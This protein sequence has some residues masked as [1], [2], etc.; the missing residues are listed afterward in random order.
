MKKV[1]LGQTELMV[2]KTSF[3]ALPI[4]RISFD[5]AGRLLREAY[6]AGVNFY[7]T[8]NAYTDSEKK[9]GQALGDVRKDIVIATKTAPGELDVMKRHL[10]QSLRDLRTDYIDIYQLHCAPKL[11]RPGE[12]DGI[13]D[14]MLEMKR[15]GVIR[16]IGITAHRIGVAEEA[17]ESGLYETLQFP[18]SVLANE[19]EIALVHTAEKRD[20]GF[21]AMK[22]MAGGLISHPEVTFA[23]LQQYPQ[24][25]P[26]YGIQR[27]E[28]LRQW[29]ALDAEPPRWD[30]RMQQLAQEEKA[31]LS[32]D[33]CRACGYCLPC[34]Q[35][36]PIPNAARLRLLMTR[37]PYKPYLT[38][39]WRAE[40]EKVS[41]CINCRQCVSRCPYSLDTPRLLRENLAWYQ[42]FCAEHRDELG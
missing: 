21:I 41:T 10:E 1:R 17:L 9:L 13:Y 25:V 32:G 3:G 35:G 36:I 4:Q 23:F 20:V 26:I 39:E 6:E 24:V 8:A 40:M 28:E 34:P 37:S 7:D 31:G 14:W 27:E 19:R 15:Q 2:T 42:G 30:E 18:F 22:A 11:Y 38:Q 16:H 5:E 33:F 29:L 12:A